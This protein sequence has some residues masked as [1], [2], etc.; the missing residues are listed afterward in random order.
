MGELK[1][2]KALFMNLNMNNSITTKE[3][4]NNLQLLKNEKQIL[5]SK[6]NNE[7]EMLKNK[8]K[9]LSIIN[10]SMSEMND[11]SNISIR[12]GTNKKPNNLKK[13][14][15]RSDLDF[16]LQLN[17]EIEKEFVEEINSD[18]ENLSTM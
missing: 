6:L 12:L 16:T 11:T 5:I 17:S 13:L 18:I 7:K 3:S 2:E 9:N 8:V 10:N 1:K 15:D 4:K 14:I